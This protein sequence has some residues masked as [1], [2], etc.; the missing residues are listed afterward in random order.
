[1]EHSPPC[2]YLQY[3]ASV[4]DQKIY[5]YIWSSLV[6]MM[7]KLAMFPSSCRNTACS[8]LECMFS[9]CYFS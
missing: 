8:Q 6:I 4:D 9:K 3:L 2:I 1:M 5:I 7:L